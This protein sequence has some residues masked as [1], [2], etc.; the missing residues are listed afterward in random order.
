V[1]AGDPDDLLRLAPGHPIVG[2][3]DFRAHC[4]KRYIES[5]LERTGWNVSAA[6]RLLGMQRTYLHQK[7]S[8]LGSQRPGTAT[9]ADAPLEDRGEADGE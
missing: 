3:R 2:L 6:A 5:V 8:A 7:I 9:A 4:E 1:D